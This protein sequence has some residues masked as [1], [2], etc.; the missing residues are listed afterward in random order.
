MTHRTALFMAGTRGGAERVSLYVCAAPCDSRGH[1]CGDV[2]RV[3]V[4]GC[5]ALFDSRG[6]SC[7]DALRVSLQFIN[8]WRNGMFEQAI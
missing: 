7:G 6:H 8:D 4:H 3:S 5:A 1:L 2:L